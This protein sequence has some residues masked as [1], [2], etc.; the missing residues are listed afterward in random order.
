[1]LSSVLTFVGVLAAI[2]SNHLRSG[3]WVLAIVPWL[4]VATFDLPIE[5]RRP[6][7]ARSGSPSSRGTSR[8]TVRPAGHPGVPPRGTPTAPVRRAAL[9][10]RALASCGRSVHRAVLPRRAA[11]A[12]VAAALVLVSVGQSSPGR[13]RSSPESP[14]ASIHRTWCSRRPA[15]LPVFAAYQQAGRRLFA[16]QGAAAAAHHRAAP[17]RPCAGALRRPRR[18]DRAGGGR[19]VPLLLRGRVHASGAK[20]RRRPRRGH[21]RGV[22]GDRPP[23][24]RGPRRPERAGKPTM[25][26]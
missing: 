24:D 25:A 22:A 13:C 7:R 6:T 23:R 10:Y 20:S 12:T 11:L 21:L 9:A 4:A 17:R 8:R 16:D 14:T 26:R 3:C 5:V 2:V 19:D 15:A 1:M 18:P